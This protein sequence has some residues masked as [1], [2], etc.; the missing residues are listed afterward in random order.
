MVLTL[1]VSFMIAGCDGVYR[2]PTVTSAD[3]STIMSVVG[4]HPAMKTIP[5]SELRS[6]YDDG[7]SWR[8]EFRRMKRKHPVL[9]FR[10][11]KKTHQVTLIE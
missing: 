2:A 7:D 9:W 1:C 8:A 11:D 10:I 5:S 6:I 4:H 3:T